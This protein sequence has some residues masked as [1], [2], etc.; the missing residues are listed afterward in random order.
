MKALNE[1]KYYQILSPS[2][3]DSPQTAQEIVIEC[4]IL[5]RW[6]ILNFPPSGVYLDSNKFRR[7]VPS[8]L[9]Q[10]D[11]H[12]SMSLDGK[13]ENIA[14]GKK[15]PNPMREENPRNI[16]CY[17]NVGTFFK[18]KNHFQLIRIEI[19]LECAQCNRKTSSD[20]IVDE[21][22]LRN[23]PRGLKMEIFWHQQ[24]DKFLHERIKRG[25]EI[26]AMRRMT[27]SFSAAHGGRKKREEK[28][29]VKW[30]LQRFLVDVEQHASVGRGS[31]KKRLL[32]SV[33]NLTWCFIDNINFELSLFVLSFMPVS[34]LSHQPTH[35]FLLPL[36]FTDYS[37]CLPVC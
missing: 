25:L 33:R 21:K 6:I 30:D 8:P 3:G 35:S 22:R 17:D 7:R 36:K 28:S 18:S 1:S 37:T 11:E 9:D 24:H 15:M 14:G 23:S 34:L 27:L 19:R 2:Q 12:N 5:L 10:R 13:D 20:D 32:C 31:S 29:E 4:E 16:F 26:D